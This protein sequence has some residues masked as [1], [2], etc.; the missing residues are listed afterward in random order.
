MQNTLYMNHINIKDQILVSK[1]SAIVY[2]VYTNAVDGNKP[3]SYFCLQSCSHQSPYASAKVSVTL[4][5]W[6]SKTS[7]I[8]DAEYSCECVTNSSHKRQYNSQ[9]GK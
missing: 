1:I 8:S 5:G 4:E 9:L 6:Q 2:G 7:S 3:V